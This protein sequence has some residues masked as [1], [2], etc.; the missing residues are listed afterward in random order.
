MNTEDAFNIIKVGLDLMP[1][2]GLAQVWS[3]V[4]WAEAGKIDLRLLQ[5]AAPGRAVNFG[6][7][8]FGDL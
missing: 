8:I 7:L 3:S 4:W 5:L 1:L 6:D 2:A